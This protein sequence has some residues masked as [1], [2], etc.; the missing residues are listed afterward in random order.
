MQSFTG[1]QVWPLDPRPEDFVIEDIAHALACQNRFAGHTRVPY[2]VGEHSV[3]VSQ[4]VDVSGCR[5]M[6]QRRKLRL[7]AL[8]HDSPE[9][10][11]NDLTRPVKHSP[12]MYGYREAERLL[13]AV[14]ELW[15]LLPLGAFDWAAVKHADAVL[16]RTEARDLMGPSP[17]PWGVPQGKAV[18]P[19]D[20]II[21]PWDWAKAEALFLK[22]H[23]ELTLPHSSL[24]P[25][26]AH[27]HYHACPVCYEEQPCDDARCTHVADLSENGV[28]FGHHAHCEDCGE[29][30]SDA[31]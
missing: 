26:P 29:E 3:R 7:A 22:R 2:S 1:R 14:M 31:S 25:D 21:V 6:D 20:E 16:L 13:S 9:T 11:L 15:A 19:L 10:Y 18:L 8:L 12:P 27:L 23:A 17:A 5:T 30:P 4:A 28:A 24:V